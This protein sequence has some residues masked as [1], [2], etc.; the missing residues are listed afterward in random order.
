MDHGVAKAF[1][2]IIRYTSFLR[3]MCSTASK[4]DETSIEV[5]RKGSTKVLDAIFIPSLPKLKL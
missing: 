4:A 1:Y 3:K 2:Y 5:T